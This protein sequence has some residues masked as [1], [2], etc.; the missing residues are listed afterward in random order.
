MLEH[1]KLLITNFILEKLNTV[2]IPDIPFGSTA[3]NGISGQIANN[4]YELSYVKNPDLIT[5]NYHEEDNAITFT[6]LGLMAK[7]RS[8][9]VE[10]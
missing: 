2:K 3:E 9:L 6:V 1:H 4:S 7:F 8:N 10:V 5:I